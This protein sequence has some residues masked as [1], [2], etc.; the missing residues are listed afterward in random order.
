MPIDDI[1]EVRD[2]P[3]IVKKAVED[4]LRAER[5]ST[6]RPEDYRFARES[7]A[8]QYSLGVSELT[9]RINSLAEQYKSKFD[10]WPRGTQ[11]VEWPVAQN[12]IWTYATGISQLPLR[13]SIRDPETGQKQQY[14]N[15]P[16]R[17][18]EPGAHPLLGKLY[19]PDDMAG[20]LA[21]PSYTS[22][23]F[24]QLVAGFS[25]TKPRGGGGG[26]RAARDPL[27]FDKRQLSMSI[28]DEWRTAL[29]EDPDDATVTQ[30]V[31]DYLTEANAFWLREAGRLDFNT[32]VTDRINAT[33]RHTFLYEKKPE[34]LSDREYMS[35]FQ[36]VVGQFGFSGRVAS[37][38]IEAGAASGAGLAG[39]GE[40]VSRTREA[41]FA[42]GGGFSRQL[43]NQMS[44][45]GS[46]G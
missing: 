28:S 10:A 2:I 6:E 7:F 34:H 14:I 8:D 43:A 17:G 35:G 9:W 45:M 36:Q 42:A 16:V 27:V 3:D 21:G 23:E 12:S 24:A 32:F 39:F 33:D 18:L 25:P 40:R 4:V 31:S 29:L 46:L 15:S 11:M 38:E 41:R 30:I 19:V 22:D 37:R 26:G 1:L 20:A 44:Q 13:F 5:Y